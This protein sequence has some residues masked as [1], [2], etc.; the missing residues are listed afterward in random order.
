MLENLNDQEQR[1][2]V[3]DM[4]SEVIQPMTWG[5]VEMSYEVDSLNLLT[6]SFFFPADGFEVETDGM[7]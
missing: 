4:N 3:W 1:Y 5:N 7:E 6:F 2:L